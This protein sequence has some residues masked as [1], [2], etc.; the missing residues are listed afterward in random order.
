MTGNLTI[1][2]PMLNGELYLQEQLDS[3][4]RQTRPPDRVFLSDDGSTDSTVSIAKKFQ[5]K[6]PFEVRI[7]DG[8][9]AGYG[10]NV[11]RLL[12]EAP[13]GH[14]AFCD[15]DDIWDE[16]RL[17]RATAAL[18]R[19]HLPTLLVCG[20]TFRP[21]R[22]NPTVRPTT[23]N[24]VQSLYR[25]QAPANATVV[26]PAATRLIKENAHL[27]ATNP[28]FPDWWI[29]SLILGHGGSLLFD[30]KPGLCY[31][32]HAGNLIGART[33]RG[34]LKRGKAI[35]S[36]QHK[37]W[38]ETHLLAL[39]SCRKALTPTNR[40]ALYKALKASRR[41]KIARFPIDLSRIP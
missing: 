35:L 13:E 34:L 28:S 38:K 12:A 37:T 7:I 10:N 33:V 14:L 26:N 40:A 27:L 39:W 31:R 5:A 22:T 19:L 32:Q 24:F 41:K 8:P 21:S 15:Q 30:P 1:C 36:G 23:A 18:F 20:R 2:L 16:F 6:A 17:E 11:M 3:L 4:L 25:N 29:Y 9:Q